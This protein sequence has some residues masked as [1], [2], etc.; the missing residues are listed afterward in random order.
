M[1][2][3]I[4]AFGKP[5]SS[6]A[7]E[8]DDSSANASITG[9][10]PTSTIS[11]YIFPKVDPDVDGVDCDKDCGDCTIRYPSRFKVENHRQLYGH[12]K[13]FTTHILVATG[14]ADWARKIKNESGSLMEAFD[15]QRVKPKSGV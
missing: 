11:P 2:K 7:S 10:K 8:E 12:I 13:P 5:P 9:A 15:K 3:S 14:R 1:L 4:F 6:A